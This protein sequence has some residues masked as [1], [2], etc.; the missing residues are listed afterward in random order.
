M[1]RFSD[2]KI[3]ELQRA[4]KVM[5]QS[6]EQKAARERLDA[7]VRV[8]SRLYERAS[9]YTKGVVAVGYASA[10][11]V[12]A[13]VK[14]LMSPAA[15]AVSGILLI[16]SVV[17]FVLWEVFENINMH[18]HFDQASEKLRGDDP[19]AAVKAID[20]YEAELQA[21]AF[22]GARLWKMVVIV[23]LG[24]ALAAVAPMVWSLL[25]H[26]WADLKG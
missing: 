2:E 12:W 7:S 10:F 6:A 8:Y 17:T 21:E 4:F 3:S 25:S 16:V 15:H 26:L 22:A 18:S 20:E 11:A 14:D 19:V 23:T 1:S 5:Q 13:F 24:T 9:A